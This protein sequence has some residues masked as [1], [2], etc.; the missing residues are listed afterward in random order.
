MKF[1]RK[2][3]PYSKSQREIRKGSEKHGK[4]VQTHWTVYSHCWRQNCSV[5]SVLAVKLS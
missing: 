1:M 5:K 4:E 3:Y 2:S